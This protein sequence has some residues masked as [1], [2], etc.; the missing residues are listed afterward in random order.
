MKAKYILK[1]TGFEFELCS[2]N[3]FSSPFLYAKDKN[4]LSW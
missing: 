4:E 3:D 2:K 1:E